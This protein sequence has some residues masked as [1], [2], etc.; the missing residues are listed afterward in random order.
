MLDFRVFGMPRSGTTWAANWL[1]TDRSICW[2]DPIQSMTP[3]EIDARG[4][5]AEYRGISCTGSWLF[6]DWAHRHPARTLIL[7]RDPL[8][9][10][11]SLRALGLPEMTAEMIEAFMALPGWRVPWSHLF[12]HDAAERIWDYLLPDIP[13]CPERHAL[14]CGMAV[15]PDFITQTPDASRLRRVID[16]LQRSQVWG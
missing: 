7:E 12:D 16:E 6:A 2:H 8:E 10:N 3:A 15:Q 1:T 11:A 13:F 14:L 4:S 5:Q 9:C